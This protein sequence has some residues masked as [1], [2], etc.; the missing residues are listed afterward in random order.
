[1]Y[2][3]NYRLPVLAKGGRLTS[4]SLTSKIFYSQPIINCYVKF[5]K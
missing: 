5:K 2:I 1:M 3:V 4:Q